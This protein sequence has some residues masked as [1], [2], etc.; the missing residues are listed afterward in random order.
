[1]LTRK[2]FGALADGQVHS[3]EA[4]AEATGVTR[5]AVWKAISQL[6][7]M[8]LPIEAQTN[9]GYRLST[10]ASR[11]MKRPSARTSPKK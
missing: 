6:R 7:E 4:L 2:I 5:S 8:G 9:R 3:G 11:W 10:P 1:M